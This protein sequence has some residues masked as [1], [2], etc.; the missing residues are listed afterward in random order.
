MTSCS[1]RVC[2][3][4]GSNIEPRL[5]F[6]RAAM[7][8]LQVHMDDLRASRI[9]ETEPEIVVDQPRF[10]NA[11]VVGTTDLGAHRLLDALQAIE[12]RF[13]RT[14]EV[15]KGPRT[16]DLDLLLYGKRVLA[17]GRLEVPH[18]GIAERDFVLVPLL[19]IL[20]DVTDP[21]DGVALSE[22]LAQRIRRGV[23][24]APRKLYTAL[25]L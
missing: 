14:R 13:G 3:G 10:L 18:P 22:R 24:R 6:V 12:A 7:L 23:Y 16:I 15:K 17:D 25:T 11:V 2:V 1:E 19:E 4:V 21:R 9:Y 5:Y 20:P 8:S